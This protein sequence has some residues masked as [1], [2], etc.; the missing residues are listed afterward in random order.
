M[1]DI[2]LTLI[3]CQYRMEAIYEYCIE[4]GQFCIRS[5]G[6]NGR[7]SP[8]AGVGASGGAIRENWTQTT[9]QTVDT[10]PGDFWKQSK[11]ANGVWQTRMHADSW[12]LW[13]HDRW[14][15]EPDAAGGLLVWG[16]TQTDAEIAAGR[17]TYS[18]R[19]HRQPFPS[20]LPGFAEQL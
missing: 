15:S 3:D 11:Q 13:E 10:I 12:K 1:Q 7:Y 2:D 18:Q 14:I 8:S 5:R 6:G 16:E 19:Q 9:A 4:A 17:L 20:G